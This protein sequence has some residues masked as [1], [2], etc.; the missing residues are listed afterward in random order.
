MR[1]LGLFAKDTNIDFLKYRKLC[2]IFS[3]VLIV[4]FIIFPMVK[5]INLGVDYKGGIVIE[6]SPIANNTLATI[7]QQIQ[8]LKLEDVSLQEFK[9]NNI[10]QITISQ[11]S[12]DKI[13][14]K[15]TIVDDIKSLLNNK[16]T[17]LKSDFVGPNVSKDLVKSGIISV[18]F[19]LL[20]IFLYVWYRFDW[21]YGLIA[22]STLIHDCII[23]VGALA[24]FNYEF[25]VTTIAAVL[26]IVG[27]SINDTIITF[28]QVKENIKRYPKENNIKLLNISLNDVFSRTVSTSLTVMLV[29]LS[30]YLWGGSALTS[31]SFTLLIGVFF[32]TYSSIYLAVPLLLYVGDFRRLK[33]PTTKDKDKTINEY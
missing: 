1:K 15:D 7:K 30:I 2:F 4:F 23:G 5:G 31:F 3:L 13:K 8:T 32:G 33:K 24:L 18:I 6:V 28:N 29:L 26:T 25:N 16:A 14:N 11:T 12:L 9:D 17:L 19:A 22:V 27:Y 21:Q 10:I 20:G